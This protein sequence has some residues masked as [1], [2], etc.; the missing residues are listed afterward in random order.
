MNFYQKTADALV[1][2]GASLEEALATCTHL[3]VG[4]HQDDLEIM[5]FE[6]IMSCFGSRE[7][8]FCGV[9]CTN[10]SGSARAGIYA[11]YTDEE[12][13]Q[14]R[15]REQQHAAILGEYGAIIQ[16]DY[17]SSEVKDPACVAIEDDLFQIFQAANAQQVY[18]HNPAD[19][20]PTHIASAV[21]SIQA[22]RR[23]PTEQRPKKVVGC[24][25]WRDLDWLPDSDK[26]GM[27]VSG[28]DNLASAL[29]ALYDSQVAGGKRYDL[30]TMGRRRA[31]AT[32]FESHGT[33]E[34][35][36]LIFGMDLTPLVTDETRDIVDY[37]L[38]YVD[39]FRTNVREN[40][41]H[42]LNG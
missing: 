30:A 36:S 4:A 25:V 5:A 18:L 2:S 41:T 8:S 31:N 26:V 19:K 24:E 6:G 9:V 16:L 15:R 32:Y 13:R 10:G 34:C 33:D 23:L 29:I 7:K 20:H 28:R 17:A 27:N 1:P 12:M 21:A 3:G 39:A 22:L 35:D 37:V 11:D 40:L 14:V 38:A 42:R